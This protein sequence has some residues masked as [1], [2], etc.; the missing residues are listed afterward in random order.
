MK[1]LLVRRVIYIFLDGVGIGGDDAAVNPLAAGL[2]P[3]LAETLG[4]T[5]AL[6]TPARHSGPVADLV[7]MDAQMGIA[8]RPQSATGQA[9]I[10]TGI[11][12]PARLNEHYGPRPDDRV[13]RVIDEG[14]VFA[15][16]RGEGLGTYFC[17]AYPAG[18]FAAV[19]RG[20]RLLSA[21][22]YAATQ[23]GQA[24]ANAADLYAARA[25]AA[26]FTNS[27]WR[28]QLGYQDAPVFTPEA[29]GE[30]LWQLAQE[31]PFLFFEHWQTDF[32]GHR[33]N[34]VGAV[35]NFV[36]FD[37][38]LAGLLAVADLEE[39]LI[40]VG[41]DHGNVEDCS[42]GKHTENPALALVFGAAR[43]SVAPRLR[44]LTDFVPVIYD[45]LTGAI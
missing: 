32:L 38:F 30:H 16:L 42:H 22:P 29:G 43:Q 7:P 17:N 40:L 6:T 14:N 9:A 1:D 10:L 11:N 24:L 41:S 8:G 37:R 5:K 3:T 45:Y 36:V 28:D 21:I 44:A 31:Q 26:D 27:G 25:I 34:L 15:Q 39:T 33:Q 12:A 23:A 13:R 20:K 19:A 35:E 18:Y 2:Y 4:D